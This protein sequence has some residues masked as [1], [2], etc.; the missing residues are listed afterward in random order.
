MK[1]RKN[2]KLRVQNSKERLRIK[3]GKDSV[4]DLARTAMLN[5]S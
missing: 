3:I 4:V 2:T 1:T 5:P